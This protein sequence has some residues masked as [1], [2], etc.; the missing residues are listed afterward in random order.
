MINLP[1]KP[2]QKPPGSIS[3]QPP[4]QASTADPEATGTFSG[5][6]STA[7]AACSAE[8]PLDSG[9]GAACSQSAL[10]CGRPCAWRREFTA[11]PP[12][13]IPG[14]VSIRSRPRSRMFRLLLRPPDR[15]HSPVRLRP[16][17]SP[18]S[19]P[20]H[21]RRYRRAARKGAIRR[22]CAAVLLLVREPKK[23]TAK[24]PPSAAGSR[25]LPQASVHLQR[26]P[27][28]SVAAV[29]ASKSASTSSAI[30]VA[31]QVQA[32]PSVGIGVGLL[33]L[34]ASVA[35]VAIQLWMIL[36]KRSRWAFVPP[37][38]G[39]LALAFQRASAILPSLWLVKTL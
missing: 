34:L 22:G 17:Q 9:R 2:V 20:F 30:T 37:A 39:G 32:E 27:G 28:A 7:T 5:W 26:K 38:V 18:R 23:E 24:V 35:A 29:P 25:P 16:L 36:N 3:T 15:L 31:P 6:W 21:R 14:S 11:A 19:R 10:G 8:A 12:P 13:G 4:S 33:A 1:P